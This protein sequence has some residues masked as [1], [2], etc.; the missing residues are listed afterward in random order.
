MKKRTSRL[1]WITGATSL[2]IAAIAWARAA[3]SSS[4][5]GPS[6]IID[7][8]NGEIRVSATVHP[9]AMERWF[10]VRGHHA[11]VWEKGRAAPWALFRSRASDEEIRIALEA[12]GAEPGENLTIE[13]WTKRD[14]P[15][16]VEPDKRVEGTPVDVSV[17]W[18]GLGEARALGSLIHQKGAPVAATDFRYGGNARFRE[19]FKSGCIVCLQSCPGGAI[20]NHARTLR[21]H[22]REGMIFTAKTEDLPSPGSSVTLIFKPRLEKP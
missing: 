5:A 17:T 22:A 14:E 20:S 7:R 2:L 1:I 13:T 12:L 18:S 9:R 6:L 10:G 11:V 3:S 21:D 4:P 15:G 8:E 16:S 19:H